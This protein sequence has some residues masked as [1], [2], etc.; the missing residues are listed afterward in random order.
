MS[1][2]LYYHFKYNKKIELFIYLQWFNLL[3]YLYTLD[4][5]IF[6]FEIVQIWIVF[7]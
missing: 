3:M 2:C 6:S 4:K 5:N 7:H 1:I